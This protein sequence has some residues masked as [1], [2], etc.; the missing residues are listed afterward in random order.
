MSKQTETPSGR[1]WA[2]TVHAVAHQIA[3]KTVSPPLNWYNNPNVAIFNANA[4]LI[5]VHQVLGSIGHD[6]AMGGQ[7]QGARAFVW[8]SFTAYWAQGLYAIHNDLI[9]GPLFGGFWA[10]EAVKAPLTS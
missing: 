9:K 6:A 1:L 4:L 3:E 5:G 7:P 2:G 8:V 10:L